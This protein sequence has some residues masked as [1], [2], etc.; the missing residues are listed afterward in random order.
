LSGDRSSAASST[1]IDEPRK[2]P[3]SPSADYWNPTGSFLDLP[4]G[5][6]VE[7]WR[8]FAVPGGGRSPPRLHIMMLR[9]YEGVTNVG[10]A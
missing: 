5:N 9:N 4:N 10:D 6:A 1:N 8:I 3:E 2:S 7:A